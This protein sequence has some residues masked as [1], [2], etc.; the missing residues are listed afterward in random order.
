LAGSRAAVKPKERKASLFRD[1]SASGALFAKPQHNR[2]NLNYM[3]SPDHGSG[4][5]IL[6]TVAAGWHV[7]NRVF[8]SSGPAGK[9]RGTPAADIM[10]EYSPL[11]R[12]AQ[13][14]Q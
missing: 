5:R 10:R 4:P 6:A 14:R 2:L 7:V 13:S 1:R 8:D 11:A 12:D 3:K 9:V